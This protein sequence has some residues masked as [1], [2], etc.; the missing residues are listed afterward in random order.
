MTVVFG[1]SVAITFALIFACRPLVKTWDASI[2]GHCINRP[3]IY[4]MT[5]VVNIGTDVVILLLSI[6]IASKLRLP[7]VQ[8]VGIVCM[9]GVGSM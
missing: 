3:A 7:L 4:V 1:Y 2:P 8:K 9:F 6:P 5:A